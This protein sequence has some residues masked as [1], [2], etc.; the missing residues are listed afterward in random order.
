MA[1]PENIRSN[2]FDSLGLETEFSNVVYS[3]GPRA[4]GRL[5]VL[6]PFKRQY[7]KVPEIDLAV[8]FQVAA[9]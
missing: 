5:V 8:I 9:D 2:C 3:Y 4:L 7:S 1:R 6:Q